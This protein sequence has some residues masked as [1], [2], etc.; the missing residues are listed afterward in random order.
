MEK[1]KSNLQ[2]KSVSEKLIVRA[3]NPLDSFPSK[4]D[5]LRT[6]VFN[7]AL[8][9]KIRKQAPNSEKWLEADSVNPDF[10]L[11]GNSQQVTIQRT[12]RRL[13]SST[14]FNPVKHGDVSLSDLAPPQP[15]HKKYVVVEE[16]RLE[17]LMKLE[18]LLRKEKEL[19]G[20]QCAWVLSDFHLDARIPVPAV[21]LAI[22]N[23]CQQQINR[24][25]LDIKNLVAEW[26]LFSKQN[27]YDKPH[28]FIKD[29]FLK[30]APPSQRAMKLKMVR[31][32]ADT[33]RLRK[34]RDTM[35][36]E[37][38]LSYLNSLYT[39]AKGRSRDYDR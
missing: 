12:F 20:E 21:R 32:A 28:L 9:K 37:D 16:S 6:A 13:Q 15:T 3:P 30:S 14:L 5:T 31:E 24:V 17:E 35:L 23:L 2:L 33:W 4:N 18:G 19:L 10:G 8:K 11:H 25:S 39:D 1:Y 34:D 29:S 7:I 26:T 27:H 22:V 36:F 38:D